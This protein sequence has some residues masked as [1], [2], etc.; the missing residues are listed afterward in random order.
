MPV[1]SEISAEAV[2]AAV[3]VHADRV[4]DAV[5]RL[6]CGPDAAVHVVRDSALDLVD[7][8][9]ADPTSVGDPVGWLFARARVLGR[10]R[11]GGPGDELPVGGGVLSGDTN[12]VRLAE[13]LELLPD[14]QRAALLLRDSYALPAAAVGTALA[15]EPT[16]ALELV[17]RARLAFLPHLLGGESLERSGGHSDLDALARLGEGG[18]VA[19]RDATARR[20]AQSCEECSAVLDVQERA[21]RLLSGLTVVA[22]PDTDRQDLIAA[23][24]Q[25]AAQLLPPAAVPVEEE[26][27]DDG[28]RRVLPLSLAAVLLL[29]AIGLGA[30]VGLYAS[31]GRQAPATAAVGGPAAFV[32]PA[33]VLTVPPASRLPAPPTTPATTQVFTITPSPVPVVTTPPPS[34]SPTATPP[35]PT[36]PASLTLAPSSG[37]NGTNV[38]VNGAGWTPGA[39]VRVGYQNQAGA[40]TPSTSSAVVQADGTF[41]TVLTATDTG[42]VPGPH[43]VTASDGTHSSEATFTVT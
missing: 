34:P 14:Q 22:L 38:S 2:L 3:R 33:P 21:H 13:A 15:L 35:S 39:T 40:V 26:P 4:H 8:V 19:A 27:W 25:R 17:A 10:S 28:P 18:P 20:H 31:R 43:R 5:R 41:S 7:T 37:P 12:Q 6:G 24:D 32:T 1:A 23:V 9:A 30:A 16:A 36:V 11:A 42:G 29:V